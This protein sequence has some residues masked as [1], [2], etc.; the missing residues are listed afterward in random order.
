MLSYVNA[1]V[2]F[3]TFDE[4]RDSGCSIFYRGFTYR[5]AL[6]YIIVSLLDTEVMQGVQGV[7]GIRLSESAFIGWFFGFR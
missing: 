7:Q 1:D 4:G 6:L 3:R 2:D 5:L